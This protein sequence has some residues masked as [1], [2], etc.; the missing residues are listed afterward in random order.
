MSKS[1]RASVLCTVALGSHVASGRAPRSSPRSRE[2]D[3]VPIRAR[4]RSAW[5]RELDPLARASRRASI[6]RVHDEPDDAA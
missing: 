4:D 1:M 5:L 3:V 2:S 6:D